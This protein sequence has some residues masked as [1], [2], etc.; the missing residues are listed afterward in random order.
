MPAHE[1]PFYAPWEAS[2]LPGPASSV[3]GA[4]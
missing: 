4:L 1:N 2:D 3:R